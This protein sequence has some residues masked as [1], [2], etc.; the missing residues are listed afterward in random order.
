MIFDFFCN[1]QPIFT[2]K[3]L[4]AEQKYQNNNQLPAGAFALFGTMLQFV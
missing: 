4:L 1:G 2:Y 3:F